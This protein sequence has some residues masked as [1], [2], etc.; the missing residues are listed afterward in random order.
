MAPASAR[1]H[2]GRPSR[3]SQDGGRASRAEAQGTR[4]PTGRGQG[5]SRRVVWWFGPQNH[6]R[7][8]PSLGRKTRGSVVEPKATGGGFRGFGPQNPGGASEEAGMARGGI[9]EVASRR[10]QLLAGSGAVHSNRGRY[11]PELGLQCLG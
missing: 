8:F 7:R 10:R 4:S 9:L 6:P 5:G 1:R 11:F 3:P 2:G